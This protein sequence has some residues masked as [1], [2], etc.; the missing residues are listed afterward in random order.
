[1]REQRSTV[2]VD[3]LTEAYAEQQWL[4]YDM[5]DDETRE[6]MRTHTPDLRLPPLERAQ[7][8]VR[9][10]MYGSKS[11]NRLFNRLP[12][13]MFWS[14][15]ISGKP[16]QSEKIKARMRVDAIVDELQK[17]IR[18]EM[19]TDH[20]LPAGYSALLREP[21]PAERAMQ[22]QVPNE[23]RPREPDSSD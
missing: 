6:R 3:L 16:N 1:M 8:G 5:A 14:V 23:T 21:H 22:E 13:E 7:L 11:V 20:V 9:A 12:A 17:V 15:P 10:S 4:E 19:E 18:V 2:Y